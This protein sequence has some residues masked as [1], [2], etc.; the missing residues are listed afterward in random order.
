MNAD[1]IAELLEGDIR[2]AQGDKL[3]ADTQILSGVPAMCDE[4]GAKLEERLQDWQIEVLTNDANLVLQKILSNPFDG[5]SALHGIEISNGGRARIWRRHTLQNLFENEI[6]QYWMLG[7]SAK[8]VSR[9]LHQFRPPVPNPEFELKE[10][11]QG[12][13]ALTVS[14]E[15]PIGGDHFEQLQAIKK[16]CTPNNF[17]ITA[18]MQH[19]FWSEVTHDAEN[20]VDDVIDLTDKEGNKCTGIVISNVAILDE[21]LPEFCTKLIGQLRERGKHLYATD[22]GEVTM[23]PHKEFTM[24]QEAEKLA[25]A[26]Q[27]K[28]EEEPDLNSVLEQ[29]RVGF[30][31]L[32]F[33]EPGN[34][35]HSITLNG[36]PAE[37]LD[38]RKQ[39]GHYF[40]CAHF[41]GADGKLWSRWK[42]VCAW[43]FVLSHCKEVF[44]KYEE[45]W[46]QRYPKD[47]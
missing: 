37:V 7:T 10:G 44:S 30:D 43:E 45:K 36:Q 35:K 13:L 31:Q 5:T 18:L 8:D 2:K 17:C 4:I 33:I 14:L 12:I 15:K 22:A 21:I 38:V 41:Y 42:A 29:T 34:H 1:Q 26:A 28:R 3:L 27:A 20:F 39:N 19:N 47:N 6:H 25:A 40:V 32:D 9:M 46:S 16:W 24:L 23:P 11:M